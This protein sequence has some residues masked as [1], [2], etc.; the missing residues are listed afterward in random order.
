MK[1]AFQNELCHVA[2][3]EDNSNCLSENTILHEISY[4]AN[5]DWKKHNPKTPFSKLE[6]PRWDENVPN[7]NN[8]PKSDSHPAEVAETK[9]I[10]GKRKQTNQTNENGAL[11]QKEEL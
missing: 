2:L 3:L 6:H 4:T 1:N 9:K 10:N 5:T 11:E 8:I 7:W